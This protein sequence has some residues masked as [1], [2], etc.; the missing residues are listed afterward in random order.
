MAKIRSTFNTSTAAH[1]ACTKTGQSYLP[2]PL[3][4]NYQAGQFVDC[5]RTLTHFIKDINISRDDYEEGYCLYVLDVDPYYSFSTKRRGH[6]HM[7]LKFAK[8][9]PESVTI[10]MYATFPEILHINQSR[11]VYQK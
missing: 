5:Y 2:Q 3:Q 9:L 8:P 6:C 7:E 10:I 1:W 11:A 4:P